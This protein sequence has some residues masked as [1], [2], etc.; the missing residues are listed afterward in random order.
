[1]SQA[2]LQAPHPEKFGIDPL[3]EPVERASR[4]LGREWRAG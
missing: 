3:R 2:D 4:G 1:M